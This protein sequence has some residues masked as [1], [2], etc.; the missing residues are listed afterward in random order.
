[1]NEKIEEE[2]SK[3]NMDHGQLSK[4]KNTPT[5]ALENL[6]RK[7]D[8]HVVGALKTWVKLT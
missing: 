6:E 5:C 1:L 8:R 4:Q 3:K 2:R 7:K